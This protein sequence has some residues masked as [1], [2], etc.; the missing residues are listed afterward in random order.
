[1]SVFISFLDRLDTINKAVD[2]GANTGIYSEVLLQYTKNLLSIEL[3]NV[4]CEII[5]N[6][7]TSQV[8]NGKQWQVIC[9]NLLHPSPAIGWLNRERKSLVERAQSSLVTALALIHHIYFSGSIDF[10]QIAEFFYSI[11]TKYIIVEFIDKEDDKVVLLSQ[12]NDTRL[13]F[14]TQE[15]FENAI[16]RYFSLETMKKVSAT[17]SLYLYIKK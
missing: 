3:D 5:R 14:Y 1:M 11:C 13:F 12:K 15:N 10:T 6:K 17:R 8:L 16:S 4:C 9:N 2:L 7:T